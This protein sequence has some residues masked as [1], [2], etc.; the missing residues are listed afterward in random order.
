MVEILENA[1]KNKRHKLC[2]S[3][4]KLASIDQYLLSELGIIMP[5]KDNSLEKRIFTVKFSEVCGGRLDPFWQTVQH[6]KMR[7]KKYQEFSV[8]TLANLQ[9]GTSITSDEII[10]GDYPVIAGGQSSPYSHN[11]YNFDGNVITVSASGA[12]SGYVWY[13]EQP[14]FASDCTVLWS[15]DEN[16]CLTIYLFEILRLKQHEL[17]NL[18]QGAG[19]PHVYPQDIE[20]VLIPLPPLDKQREI[21]ANISAIRTEAKRLEQEGEKLLQSAR[22]QVEKMILGHYIFSSTAS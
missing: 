8:K 5:E 15:I 19:Q 3:K 10:E 11:E 4:K 13:H 20:K 2:E 7:S 14:I 21:V 17:Y 18:Q 9:K 16:K 12:Y 6:E 1:Q 22:Q